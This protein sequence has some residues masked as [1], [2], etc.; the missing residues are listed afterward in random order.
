MIYQREHELKNNINLSSKKI[1]FFWTRS[2]SYQQQ[3][4]KK[5]IFFFFYSI[6]CKKEPKAKQLF[7][8]IV[9]L[10][11]F[12]RAFSQSFFF[13]QKTCISKRLNHF[14]IF[15]STMF[16][17]GK[18]FSCLLEFKKKAVQ[19][20]TPVSAGRYSLDKLLFFITFYFLAETLK[21]D[22]S[23]VKIVLSLWL[24]SII[25]FIIM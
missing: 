11:F 4:K 1:C 22:L 7:Q 19:Y 8:S 18:Q 5:G 23:Y 20:T 2:L 13:K 24:N 15:F 3:E 21:V 16:M 12:G 10:I 25:Y 17:F 6:W 14:A 9:A